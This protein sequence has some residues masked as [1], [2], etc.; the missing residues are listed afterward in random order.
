MILA[1]LPYGA[2]YI[3]FG[4]F[5]AGVTQYLYHSGESAFTMTNSRIVS[6][7]IPH[8]MIISRGSV[9]LHKHY[10]SPGKTLNS[11]ELVVK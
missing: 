8:E 10:E 9:A 2:M 4:L 6:G 5:H 7:G 3:S 1:S 11:S